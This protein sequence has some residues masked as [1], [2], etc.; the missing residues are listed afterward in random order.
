MLSGVEH[1]VGFP[2]F[3]DRGDDDFAHI[4]RQQRLQLIAALGGDQV[5]HIG[6]VEGGRDL[7]V[8]IDPIDDDQHGRVLHV[9]HAQFLRGEDHQQ[10][11]ARSLKMPDEAL[12][13]PTGDHALNDLIGGLILLVSGREFDAAMFLVGGEER[14]VLQDVEHDVGPQHTQRGGFQ[15]TRTPTLPSPVF[16]PPRRPDFERHADRAEA[17]GLAFG[18][19]G[20]DVGHEQ[21]GDVDFVIVLNL[22]RA[23]DPRD[24]RAHGR[25]AFADDERQAVDKQNEIGPTRLAGPIGILCGDDEM[26]VPDRVEVDQPHGGVLIVRAKGHGALAAQPGGEFFVGAHEAVAGHREQ[27][28]TQAIQHFVGA[29]GLLGDS[30]FSAISASRTCASTSTSLSARGS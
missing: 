19:E 5:G 17:I 26:I 24:G 22:R 16:F 27:N 1:A 18:G 13:H 10:R 30:G 8:E 25:F 2:E 21:R 4:L 12:L 6:G 9:V 3:M 15:L 28:G 20:E 29:I 7:R 11:F 23:I 14:E